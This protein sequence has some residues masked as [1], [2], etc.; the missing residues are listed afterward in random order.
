MEKDNANPTVFSPTV[1]VLGTVRGGDVAVVWQRR[2]LCSGGSV[3]VSSLGV[4]V[5]RACSRLVFPA[6][7]VKG[8]RAAL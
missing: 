7:C 3:P 6:L 8:H 2:G 4:A 1:R 5:G